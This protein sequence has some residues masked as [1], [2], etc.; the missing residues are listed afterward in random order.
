LSDVDPQS[1]SN[2]LGMLL[3]GRDM[4]LSVNPDGLNPDIEN[5]RIKY[6]LWSELRGVRPPPVPHPSPV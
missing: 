6:I 3:E 1:V 4:I 2:L 5:S